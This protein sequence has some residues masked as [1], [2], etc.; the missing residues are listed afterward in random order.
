VRTLCDISEVCRCSGGALDWNQLTAHAHAYK[1]GKPVYYALRLARDLVGAGVPARALTKLRTSFFQLSLEEGFIAAGTRRA[2]LSDDQGPPPAY[3]LGARLLASCRARDG[4]RTDSR[5]AA[6]AHQTR[7][8]RAASMAMLPFRGFASGI[9]RSRL[10]AAAIV[11]PI[12]RSRPDADALMAVDRAVAVLRHGNWHFMA[13]QSLDT[14]FYDHRYGKRIVRFADA[15]FNSP[16][17]Y[18]RLLLTDEFYAAFSQYEYILITHDDAYVLRDDLPKWL[19]RRLDYIGAPWWPDGHEIELNMSSRHGIRGLALKSYVGNGG[20]SLRRVAACRQLL[21]EFPEEAACFSQNKW[22]EDLFFAWFGQLSQRFVLPSLRVAAA[23]AWE[24]SL[25]QMYALC[26]G[27][28]PMAIH[29]FHGYDPEFF[30]RFILPK[31]L[32]SC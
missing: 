31:A 5:H 17:D 6:R 11:L 20:F 9:I 8:R 16:Q 14:S 29:A 2:I 7:F 32:S 23:F 28:L 30:V 24:V 26:Q 3:S 22:G 21:A 19:L 12:Y 10:P 13:P 4:I 15:H 25:P 18:S 27:Q 1:I